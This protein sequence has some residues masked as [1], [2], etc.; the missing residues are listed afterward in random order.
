V[1]HVLLLQLQSNNH[2]MITRACHVDHPLLA[3]MDG[4]GA[5]YL[6]MV[7]FG[8]YAILDMDDGSRPPRG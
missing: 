8:I 2:Q 4:C 1:P 6:I 7:W 3:L 5:Y